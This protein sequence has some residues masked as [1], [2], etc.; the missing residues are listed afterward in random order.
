MMRS[1]LARV[2]FGLFV[3]TSIAAT[4]RLMPIEL[5]TDNVPIS[6]ARIVS[7]PSGHVVA[8][9]MR[10]D[11]DL[12][13][14]NDIV[15]R[16]FTPGIGWA[17]PENLTA[18]DTYPQDAGHFAVDADGT[19]IAVWDE[20][21]AVGYDHILV[22]R[23]FVPGRGWG[24]KQTLGLIWAFPSPTM[25]PDGRAHLVYLDGSQFVAR[26]LTP[27][28]DVWSEPFVLLGNQAQSGGSGQVVA[29]NG[30]AYATL[31]SVMEDENFIQ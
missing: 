5:E 11:F 27:G 21:P 12:P 23:K 3:F 29:A 13:F 6:D 20:I 17:A 1:R 4:C 9:W 19:V 31:F 10:S 30:F 26:T 14:P 22:S 2:L 28:E 15:A 8:N 18:G 7:G 24:P 25:S 16:I